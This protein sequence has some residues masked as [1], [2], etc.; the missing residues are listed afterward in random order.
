VARPLTHA[1]ALEAWRID[2]KLNG[3][4]V[5]QT[6]CFVGALQDL[7]DERSRALPPDFVPDDCEPRWVTRLRAARLSQRPPQ[8]WKAPQQ[9]N[10]P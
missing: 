7:E 3:H 9:W 2:G 4:T 10:Q 6:L 1:E 5:Q 8:Q